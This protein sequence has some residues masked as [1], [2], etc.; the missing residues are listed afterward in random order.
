MKYSECLEIIYG[1][2][3]KNPKKYS[4]KV[5]LKIINKLIKG[6]KTMKDHE[7][8]SFLYDLKKKKN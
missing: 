1:L 5:G 8:C 6:F 4:N 7:K 3:K 2:V